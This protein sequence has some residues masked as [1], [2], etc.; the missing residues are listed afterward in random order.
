MRKILYTTTL[1]TN[2]FG[3]FM[4]PMSDGYVTFNGKATRAR[5]I[6]DTGATN[7]SIPY[8]IAHDLEVHG[9]GKEIEVG[10]AGGSS[11]EPLCT[12]GVYVKDSSFHFGNDMLVTIRSKK[13]K[14]RD[15]LLGM[16]VISQFDFLLRHDGDKIVFE[17]YTNV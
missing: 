15:V 17:F 9:N 6:W 7:T 13:D 1:T 4:S 11:M 12:V 3:A 5:I 8:S 2:S 16:D 10:N 14:S